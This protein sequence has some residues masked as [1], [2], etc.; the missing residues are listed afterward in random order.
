MTNR[1]IIAFANTGS[2]MNKFICALSVLL[3][4]LANSLATY[5]LE[6]GDRA[7]D[8]TLQASDGEVYTLSDYE[9][10]IMW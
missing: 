8:F 3:L 5:A 6:V 2:A 7:P 9:G 4:L 1:F 10:K